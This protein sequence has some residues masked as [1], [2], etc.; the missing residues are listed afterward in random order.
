MSLLYN[1]NWNHAKKKFTGWWKGEN[2]P[3]PLLQTLSHRNEPVEDVPEPPEPDLHEQRWLDADW[4]IRSFEYRASRTLF[5]GDALPFFDPHLGP[6]TMA[7][8]LGCPPTWDERTVW[9]EPIYDDLKNAPLPEFDPDNRYF[10]WSLDT[11]R[12]AKERLKGKA[13]V[14][15]PDLVEGMDILASLVG[16]EKLLYYMIDSPD[17]VHKFLERINEL[18]FKFYDPIYEASKDEEGGSC[19]SAFSF[20]AP[21]RTAK[22]QCDMSA[23]ISPDMFREFVQPYLREQCKKLDY[24]VYHWDGP[25]AISHLNALL[26]IDEIQAIQWTPGA[27]QPGPGNEIWWHLYKRIV[28][29]G[30]SLM[31]NGASAN[32][33][34]PLIDKFGP[35]KLDILLW[36]WTEEDARQLLGKYGY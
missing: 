33:V 13:L 23:M 14:A 21:G 34:G 5:G 20:W 18:Y 8:Y 28:D 12:E 22:V 24:A 27:G 25:D 26:E 36:L 1:P 16:T 2:S 35:E 15:I 11:A 17:V 29:V 30:K 10:K 6:G 31:I 3:T 19:F 7:L 9:Y 32:E 4:R